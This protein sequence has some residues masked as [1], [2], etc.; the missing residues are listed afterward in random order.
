GLG[1]QFWINILLTLL[2]YIPG[3]IHAVY[4]IAKR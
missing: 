4:I 1:A 3:L 2:G